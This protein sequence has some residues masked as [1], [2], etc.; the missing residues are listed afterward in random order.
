M[1]PLALAPALVILSA[2]L[3]SLSRAEEPSFQLLATAQ[4][5]LSATLATLWAA[6][7]LTLLVTWVIFDLLLAVGNLAA[8]SPMRTA[9]RVLV[10]GELSTLL[11]WGGA[12]LPGR[13]ADGA[14]WSLVTPS[15]AQLALWAAAGVLRLGV[16]PFHLTAPD[17]LDRA[18]SLA[19]PLALSTIVGWGLWMRL[20][21]L[22]NN[23]MPGE[24]WVAILAALTLVVGA[25]LAWSCGNLHRALSWAS[26]S[27]TGAV[28]LAAMLGGNSATVIISAGSLAWAL[29]TGTV[30]LSGGGKR[31]SPWW[32]IPALVGGLALLGMPLTLGF[33]ATAHLISGL[34]LQESLTWGIAFIA[35]NLLLV[36]ALARGILSGPTHPELS[37]PLSTIA[38]GIGL[39]LPAMLLVVGGLHPPLLSSNVPSPPLGELLAMPNLAGWL[40]WAVSLACGGVLAWQDH[41]VRPKIELVLGAIHDLLSLG[42]LYDAVLGALDRGLGVMRAAD[43]VVGGEGALLW[44][45][46][47]FLLILLLW[48]GQPCPR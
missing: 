25:L 18:P 23:A 32:N 3:V 16:F 35:G 45:L 22:S 7:L 9:V 27:V 21:P 10:V 24:P 5:V 6:N 31:E 15:N 34:P 11:L 46:L 38:Q 48:G 30:L 33:V 36:P 44:S 20:I 39:G 13:G 28:L 4:A 12:L 8:G 47:L 14:L 26:V 40:L 17:Y 37:T 19:T 2:I 42:W 41:T 1:H 43:E 29:G